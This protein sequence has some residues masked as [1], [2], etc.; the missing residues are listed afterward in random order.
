MRSAIRPLI[1]DRKI[2]FVVFQSN[3]SEIIS[4]KEAQEYVATRPTLK[5]T[6][7]H[8][9]I[10]QGTTASPGHIKGRVKIVLNNNDLAK[11]QPGDILVAVMTTPNFIMAMEKAAAFVTD[12][13]GIL[14]HAAIVSRE[15]GK[16][17]IIGTKNA[18]KVFK[19]GDLVE[20][21]AKKGVIRK[22]K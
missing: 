19:D 9:K 17:C 22:I 20:V 1:A 12:E 14:Y 2:D 16:P 4:G 5:H 13:G 7:V 18:T 3:G 8:T 6:I 11:V 21:D 10:L 15:M